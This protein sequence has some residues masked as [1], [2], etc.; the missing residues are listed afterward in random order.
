MPKK[1]EE[2]LKMDKKDRLSSSPSTFCCECENPLRDCT[3]GC[4]KTKQGPMCDDCYY[5]AMSKHID[6]N[7]IVTP[8]DV[9]L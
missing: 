3:T 9:E 8:T 5:K 2:I 1:V 4:R 6:K 7:P